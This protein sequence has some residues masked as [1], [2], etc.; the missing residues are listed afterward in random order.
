MRSRSNMLVQE[1]SPGLSYTCLAA[2]LSSGRRL[3]VAGTDELDLSEAG[4]W[5]ALGV[6]TVLCCRR[7]FYSL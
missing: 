2:I 6:S 4:L 1:A 5:S 7:E 3:L